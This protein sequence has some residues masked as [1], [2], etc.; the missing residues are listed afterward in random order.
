MV[1]PTTRFSLALDFCRAWVSYSD[2]FNGKFMQ[3]ISS[4]A[5]GSAWGDIKM[6]REN[7]R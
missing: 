2:Q 1:P 5:R 3:M 4:E 6:E 7:V